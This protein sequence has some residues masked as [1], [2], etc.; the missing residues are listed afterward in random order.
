MKLDELAGKRVH[1]FA[2]IMQPMK[3]QGFTGSTVTPI[4]VR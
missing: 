1:E 4:A 2:F 3:L